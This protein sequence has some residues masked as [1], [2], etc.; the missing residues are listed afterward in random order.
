MS[1]KANDVKQH[2]LS[3][4][5][6]F[7][8]VLL[9]QDHVDPLTPSGMDPIEALPRI[10]M[11]QMLSLQ[12]SKTI[13]SRVETRAAEQGVRIAQLS[14]DDLLECGLSRNKA[15]AVGAIEVYW[16]NGGG[17]ME[18]WRSLTCDELLHEVQTIKGVGP[19]SASI[20]AMFHF[21]HEDLFPIQD[22]SLRKAIALLKE[23][24]VIIIPERASPYR[25]YLA[26][27]LWQLL[28]QKRI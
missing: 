3:T 2:L 9:E 26:C 1:E 5:P 14:Y 4:Q 10:V 28:D 20:L 17:K 7:E 22:S 27:Y 23:R 12:A 21:G 15:V 6:G 13:I 18:Q 8:L 25:S 19:W 11:R 16:Q 24:D